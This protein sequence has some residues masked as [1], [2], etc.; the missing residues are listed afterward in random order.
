MKHTLENA[1]EM[2]RGCCACVHESIEFR[3]GRYR[4]VCGRTDEVHPI[5]HRGDDRCFDPKPHDEDA[6]DMLT[7]GQWRHAIWLARRFGFDV[8]DDGEPM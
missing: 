6:G 2:M 8:D 3:D 7:D 1:T 4:A 5:E